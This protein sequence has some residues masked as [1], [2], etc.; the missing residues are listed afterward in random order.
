MK[1]DNI[2]HIYV[3]L[4][5]DGNNQPALERAILAASLPQTRV[6]LLC[7]VYN[8][9]LEHNLLLNEAQRRDG[10]TQWINGHEQW[11][12]RELETFRKQHPKSDARLL[13][14]A[15]TTTELLAELPP[16]GETLLIRSPD[17]RHLVRDLLLPQKDWELIRRC[18]LPLWLPRQSIPLTRVIACVDPLHSADPSHARDLKIIETAQ[19]LAQLTQ[20]PMA[21][22]HCYSPLSHQMLFDADFVNAEATQ[23]NALRQRHRAALPPLLESAGISEQQLIMVEGQAEQVL[24]KESMEVPGTLVVIGATARGALDSAVIGNT[25]ERVLQHGDCELLIC[26]AATVLRQDH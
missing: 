9:A 25:A 22:L 15:D 19:S 14:G 26:P 4:R 23:T 2:R 1:I 6:S 12:H 21:V 8:S 11:L 5:P 24:K 7:P 20:T 16:D 10:R 3:V 18:P 17:K 13:Y